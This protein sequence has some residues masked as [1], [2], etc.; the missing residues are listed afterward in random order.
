MANAFLVNLSHCLGPGQTGPVGQPLEM[1][2]VTRAF[3]LFHSKAPQ[4]QKLVPARTLN[5]FLNLVGWQVQQGLVPPLALEAERA[6]SEMFY[7]YITQFGP[8]DQRFPSVWHQFG[9]EN[10]DTVEQTSCY[11]AAQTLAR[12]PAYATKGA[13][14]NMTVAELAEKWE[15]HK[16]TRSPC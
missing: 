5:L 16:A 8:L 6:L 11:L 12:D 14:G 4:V 1:S 15:V 3:A 9:S 7:R 2:Y 13:P 10:R